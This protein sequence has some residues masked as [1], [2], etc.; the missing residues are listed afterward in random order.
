MVIHHNLR[1]YLSNGRCARMSEA[2]IPTSGRLKSHPELT[3]ADIGR[4]RGHLEAANLFAGANIILTY[5]GRGALYLLA[6][7]LPRRN[8]RSVVLLPAFHCPTVVEPILRAGYQPRFYRISETLSIDYEDFLSKLDE[9]ICA[10]VI[11]NYFGFPADLEAAKK[12]CEQV[13]AFVIEDCAHSFLQTAPM[14]LTGSR[15]HAATYSF[16]KLVPTLVGG[17]VRINDARLR[18]ETP[19][20]GAPIRDTA[21]NCKRL[22]EQAVEAL[23]SRNPGRLAFEYL[24]SCRL[25]L[26][27]GKEDHSAFSTAER[28]P[29]T[30]DYPFDERLAVCKMPGY[31][32][33]ILSRANL[34]DV[35][36]RRR[37]NFEAFLANL[38]FSDRLRP[39]FMRLGSHVCPWAFPVLVSD[40]SRIDVKL[41]DLGVALF[42]FGETL[43]GALHNNLPA[44][45]REAAD[46]ARRLSARL[47]CLSIHQGLTPEDIRREAEIVNSL[48]S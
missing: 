38:N 26:K 31:A 8:S 24:E 19:T 46:G 47:L 6:R 39:V 18:L 25:W 3:F 12:A 40:R 14:G 29:A 36:A 2:K 22:F 1:N 27:G 4:H 5:N 23:D 34:T 43:H 11:I 35:A 30:F 13:D 32:R 48:L 7:Q 20:V 15:G 42:T 41:R 10:A 45:E 28:S 9:G 16:K 21:V 17:G 37:Q 44:A 33:R